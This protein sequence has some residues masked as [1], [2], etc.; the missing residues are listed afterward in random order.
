MRRAA[1]QALLLLCLQPVGGGMVAAEVAAAL[2]P[3]LPSSRD[4]DGRAVAAALQPGCS[5]S[6]DD[7]VTA[8]LSCKGRGWCRV[9]TQMVGLGHATQAGRRM[10]K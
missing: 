4:A 5:L 1:W 9:Y 2:A 7:M 3:V 6:C 10:C 8:L